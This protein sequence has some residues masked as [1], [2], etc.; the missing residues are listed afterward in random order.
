MSDDQIKGQDEN[1]AEDTTTGVTAWDPDGLRPQTDDPAATVT[2]HAETVTDREPDG[3]DEDATVTSRPDGSERSPVEEDNG[4]PADEEA[5]LAARE[6]SAAERAEYGRLEGCRHE[7]ALRMR[8]LTPDV[9]AAERG[10]RHG[11][12]VFS[13]LQL[14]QAEHETASDAADAYLREHPDAVP[15]Y[16]AACRWQALGVSTVPVRDDGSKSPFGKWKQYQERL[17]TEQELWDWHHGGTSGL[18][19][20]TGRTDRADGLG[21]KMLELEGRAVA[22]GV[23]EEFLDRIA[24]AGLAECW[25]RI[26]TGYREMS[27]SGGVHFY[28][29]VADSCGNTKLAMRYAT[30]EELAENPK[31]KYRTL[32][33]TRGWG[34]FVVAAPT[35]GSFQH[36]GRPWTSEGSPEA[37]PVISPEENEA[38]LDCA[39]ACNK[40]PKGAIHE[41]P[42]RMKHETLNGPDRSAAGVPLR[43]RPGDVFNQRGPDWAELLEPYGWRQDRAEDDGTIHWTRPGKAA[44]TSATTGNPQHEGDKFHVFI[45][46]TEFEPDTACSKF[47]VFTILDHGGDWRAAAAQ[48]ARDGYVSHE[49]VCAVPPVAAEGTWAPQRSIPGA[50]GEEAGGR[51]ALTNAEE[52]VLLLRWAI[53]TG[54]LSDKVFPSSGKLVGVELHTRDEIAA[55]E[56]EGRVMSRVE[57]APVTPELLRWYSATGHLCYRLTEEEGRD[58]REIPDLPAI[59][60]AKVALASSS[61]R[62]VPV[63]A[64]VTTVPLLKPGGTLLA[65]QG[66]DPETGLIYWPEFDVGEITVSRETVREAKH[67]LKGIRRGGDAQAAQG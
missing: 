57:L 23:Y 2:D 37:M 41:H 11:N 48:L 46:S 15:V 60:H 44:G 33:E 34:G 61:Y 7:A 56:A 22:A 17:P 13:R 63:V 5:A 67:F 3:Q 43:T 14:A 25:H 51:I 62:H 10:S 59:G 58:P 38:I 28:W 29:L 36:S 21:I 1:G 26:V 53:E 20:V 31:D 42:E 24:A 4:A 27:P 47:A 12:E 35:P 49:A 30:A 55:A 39:R 6:R 9:L 16:G 54:R 66:Y 19:I 64:G 65:S 45:S 50:P 40:V 52:I 32:I 18:G 8:R